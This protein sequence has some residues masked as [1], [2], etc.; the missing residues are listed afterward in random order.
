MLQDHLGELAKQKADLLVQGMKIQLS[1]IK[2]VVRNVNRMANIFA[3]LTAIEVVR[4]LKELP[5]ESYTK[6]VTDRLAM[7]IQIIEEI[8][9]L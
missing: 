3:L 4:A 7:W 2:P 5:K 9:K 1:Q 6:P 8:Q